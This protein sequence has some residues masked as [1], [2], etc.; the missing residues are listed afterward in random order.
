[1]HTE[2]LQNLTKIGVYPL[3][4]FSYVTSGQRFFPR[5][6]RVY[7][8]QPRSSLIWTYGLSMLKMVRTLQ[9]Y[10]AYDVWLFPFFNFA[11]R[12]GM[13]GLVAYRGRWEIRRLRLAWSWCAL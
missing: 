8:F 6:D 13:D 2:D 11:I 4:F 3:K 1:M 7:D 12:P 10:D 5:A 9:G